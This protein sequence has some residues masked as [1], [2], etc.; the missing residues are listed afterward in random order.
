MR[1]FGIFLFSLFLCYSVN[2]QAQ[3]EECG[4]KTTREEMENFIQLISTSPQFSL[5]SSTETIYFAV[6]HHVVRQNNGVGGLDA[7]Y[8]EK[9]IRDLNTEFASARIQFFTQGEVI[10][11]NN[12][13]YFNFTS[14][15]NKENVLIN[16]Y[17]SPNAIN[18]YY[19]NSL[20]ANGSS[21]SG[22]T[23][24]PNRIGYLR[25][26]IAI[27][28]DYA[29]E[30]GGVTVVHEMGHFLG[31]Y[32]THETDNGIE[33]PNG[34]NCSNAGDLICDTPADPNLQKP[35]YVVDCQYVGTVKYNGYSYNPDV[36]NFMNYAHHRCRTRFTAGQIQRM[37]TTVRDSR[38][39]L[40]SLTST[41]PGSEYVVRTTVNLSS[42]S[43]LNYATIRIVSGGVLNANGGTITAGKI[44]VENGG[45][46]SGTSGNINC[47]TFD[48]QL[49][50][51]V[52]LNIPINFK[53]Q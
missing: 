13:D 16:N 4:T 45:R 35:G 34:S 50:S 10:Y 52:V 9:V 14:D 29:E 11:I 28:N 39:G 36:S 22:Y 47:Q 42:G 12:S 21:A 26:F 3:I 15:K 7:Y 32:H 5:R 31:L 23:Y 51:V 2:L 43:T 33:H 53:V 30:Y 18:I 46:L 20:I 25:N 49:G 17:N 41:P 37:N 48:A 38:F 1:I 6:K 24:I 8:I 19:F 44:I 27:K 40:I